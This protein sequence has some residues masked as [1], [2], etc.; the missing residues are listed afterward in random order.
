MVDSVLTSQAQGAAGVRQTERTAARGAIDPLSPSNKVAQRAFGAVISAAATPQSKPVSEKPSLEKAPIRGGLL[1]TSAQVLLA[2]TRS[3]EA[4]APFRGNSNIG[5]ATNIYR[6]TQDR[7]SGTIR[8]TLGQVS[9]SA[10][11]AANSNEAAVA[12]PLQPVSLSEAEAKELENGIS[13]EGM[14]GRLIAT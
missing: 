3:F 4:A 6:Q 11:G 1:S 12:E 13:E 5:N 10:S 7:V 2:E 14:L 8:E 9:T